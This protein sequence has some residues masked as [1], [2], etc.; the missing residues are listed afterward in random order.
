MP[1]PLSEACQWDEFMWVGWGAGLAATHRPLLL[2]GGGAPF[3]GGRGG[4]VP[5]VA[6]NSLYFGIIC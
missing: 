4:T 5:T 6:E 3:A 2:G 1:D